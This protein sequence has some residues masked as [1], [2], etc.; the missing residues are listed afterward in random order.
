MPC[1]QV[2]IQTLQWQGADIDI[3]AAAL[4]AEG[5]TVAVSSSRASLT[6]RKG[7]SSVL[8]DGTQLTIQEGYGTKVDEN[9]IRRA[10]STQVVR[11]TAKKFGWKVSSKDG[12]R[13]TMR[14]SF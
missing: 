13:G 5:W 4:E 14:R 11:T 2:R 7:S 3:L 10:Y 1:D 9:T 6:A 12:L 8:Y